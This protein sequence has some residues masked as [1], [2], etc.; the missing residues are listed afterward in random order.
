M[1]TED[2]IISPIDTESPH[3]FEHPDPDYFDDNHHPGDI[4][5]ETPSISDRDFSSPNGSEF[6]E[7]YIDNIVHPSST[8]HI[9]PETP[10]LQSRYNTFRPLPKTGK[11]PI[12]NYYAEINWKNGFEQWPLVRFSTPADNSCL[13]HAI[14]NSFF[15][16]YHTETLHGKHVPRNR[17]IM[18]LRKELSQKLAAKISPNPDKNGYHPTHY[19]M[20]NGGNTSAFADFVPEFKLEYMQTQLESPV[21]IGYGYMEFIGNVLN[22]DIYILEA[23]R[24]DIYVTDELSLTIKGTRNSIV[25]YYM[26]GHYELVGIQNIDGSFDTHFSPNHSLIRFLHNRVCQIT[27]C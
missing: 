16:P 9:L 23:L 19:D 18:G 5:F 27:G 24:H 14:S 22:K 7:P 25:L 4:C 6:V 2:T 17:M 10:I 11:G 20:L 13:F 12:G 3:T 1:S 8:Q 26:N 21:P 15:D